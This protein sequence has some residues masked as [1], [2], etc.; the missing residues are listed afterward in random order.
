MKSIIKLRPKALMYL[1]YIISTL[2]KLLVS[3]A[4]G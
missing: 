4:T 1:N 3:V 2:M